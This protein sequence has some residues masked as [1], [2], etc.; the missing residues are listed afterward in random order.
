MSEPIATVE[1]VRSAYVMCDED[2]IAFD[3][4]LASVKADAWDECLDE[5]EANYLNLQQ[6]RSGNPY[7]WKQA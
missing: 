5:I 3:V 7:R 2:E 6:A 4:W 1:D